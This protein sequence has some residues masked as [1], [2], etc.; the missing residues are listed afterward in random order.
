MYKVINF[1]DLEKYG[2]KQ[3]KVACY[4]IKTVKVVDFEKKYVIEICNDKPSYN[5]WTGKDW[6]DVGILKLWECKEI[7]LNYKWRDGENGVYYECDKTHNEEIEKYIQD[8][9]K[10]K[11]IEVSI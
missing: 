5:M 1:E 10:D 2:F 3:S 9:I 4:P 6:K 11:I 8:L 7:D